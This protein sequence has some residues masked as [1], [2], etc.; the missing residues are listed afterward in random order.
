MHAQTQVP[1]DHPLMLAWEKYLAS[2]EYSN[3]FKWAGKEE[4]RKGSI[5]AAFTKG[6]L[7]AKGKEYL[8]E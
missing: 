6:W 3:S 8:D 7:A 2:D 4:H 1:K 5:W